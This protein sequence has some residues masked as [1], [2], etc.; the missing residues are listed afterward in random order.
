[1][2]HYLS[3]S[4]ITEDFRDFQKKFLEGSPELY[5]DDFPVEFLKKSQLELLKNCLEKFQKESL[6]KFIGKILDKSTD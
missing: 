4:C 1:M 6:R 5:P 2:K 3:N